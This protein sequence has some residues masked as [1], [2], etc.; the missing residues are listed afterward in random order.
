MRFVDLFAGLG[1]F[2]LGLSRLGHKC[3]LA[4]EIDES[5]RQLYHRNFRLL[6][7]ADIRALRATEVPEHEIL[8]AGFPCQ[9]FSK[10]G[11]QRGF[12]CPTNGDLL[13][14]VV[15]ILR[16][17]RPAYLL[18]ENVPNFERHDNGATLKHLISSL[19]R[20]GY[21]V[22]YRRLSPHH[23]G[24]PQIRDRLYIVGA[25]GGLDHF[26]WPRPT[27]R[28]TSIRPFL[29]Q[30]PDEAKQLP[31]EVEACLTVWQR[32]LDRMPKN[33]DFPAGPIWAME[34]GAT[35]PY[36]TETPFSCGSQRLRRYKGAFGVPL[37]SQEDAWS[38]LP[39]HARSRHKR[40][41]E[42][43]VRFIRKNREF[44]RVNRRWI[45]RWLPEIRE[46][47]SSRQKL[48]WNC[49]GESRNIWRYVV[50]LR[51]SGVRVKRPTTSPSLV[52][53]TTTQVPIIAWE[54][55]YMTP[56]ECAH[57]QGMGG[58]PNLPAVASRAFS[59]LG[60]AVNADIVE[61]IGASLVPSVDLDPAILRTPNAPGTEQTRVRVA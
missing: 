29:E 7:E 2:H 61:L 57:L 18:L 38:H 55:R 13:D 58:L 44:Y 52:A 14:H 30:R 35:Y 6:P 23:F 12:D 27:G 60:N 37:T 3:V 21:A 48:E 10:A 31:P 42:W 25:R 40:F 28:P 32:F 19:S 50:Q 39:S 34:F 59:A 49:R 4:C 46:F 8:A 16:H 17:R 56:R 22:E 36:E 41:P 24:I 54:R 20:L 1:G 9:P 47:P 43:K 15:R 11:E 26:E 5:L 33:V 45:D 51:A 53:M